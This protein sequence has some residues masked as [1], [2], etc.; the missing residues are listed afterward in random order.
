MEWVSNYDVINKGKKY[1]ECV[2]INLITY[3]ANDLEYKNEAELM[4]ID[5]SSKLKR[6]TDDLENFS[7][8][9]KEK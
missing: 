3:F 6:I 8:Y 4:Y 9:K 5:S 1:T 2:N 7:F